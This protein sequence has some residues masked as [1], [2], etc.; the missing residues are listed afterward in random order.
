M[1]FSVYII[2]EKRS[3]TENETEI[4]KTV[5]YLVHK[6]YFGRKMRRF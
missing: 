2:V 6:R 1:V 4:A 3:W 5:P